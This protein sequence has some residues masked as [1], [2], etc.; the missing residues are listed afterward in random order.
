MR[1][2]WAGSG[3]A[4]VTAM[5]TVPTPAEETGYLRYTQS[6]GVNAFLSLLGARADEFSVRVAGRSLARAEDPAQDIPLAV[7]AEKAAG[8]PGELVRS[9]PTILVVAAQP[10]ANLVPGLLEPQSEYGFIRYR[11]FGLVPEPGG[12]FPILRSTGSRALPVVP[13]ELWTY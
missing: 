6:E 5:A 10:G 9:K 8:T 13:Y 11:K 4:A 3:V 7:L 1:C 2:F 12:V